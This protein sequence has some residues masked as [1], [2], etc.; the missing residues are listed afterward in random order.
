MFIQLSLLHALLVSK[1]VEPSLHVEAIQSVVLPRH[2]LLL[3]NTL[4]GHLVRGLETERTSHR[5]LLNRRS[6]NFGS[7]EGRHGWHVPELV[8]GQPWIVGSREGLQGGVVNTLLVIATQR[9]LLPFC[10]NLLIDLGFGVSEVLPCDRLWLNWSLWFN[11]KLI[12]L[13]FQIKF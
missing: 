2:Y 10:A 12:H 6:L 8:P 5:L 13:L 11:T 3:R 4:K 7:A 1:C 9:V